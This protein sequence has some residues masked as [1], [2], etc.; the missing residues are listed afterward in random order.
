MNFY[1]L[2]QIDLGHRNDTFRLQEWLFFVTRINQYNQNLI[3]LDI[4][5]R[6]IF[7]GYNMCPTATNVF[8]TSSFVS[9]Q[10][11]LMLAPW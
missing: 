4:F 11:K 5:A 9:G 10:I 8:Y 7:N 1:F 6:Q 2:I 3:A